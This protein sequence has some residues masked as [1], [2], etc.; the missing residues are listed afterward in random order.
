ML[1]AAVW[2]AC[3]LPEQFIW[4]GAISGIIAGG[5]ISFIIFKMA[6]MLFTSLAGTTITMTGMLA[7]FH[8]YQPTTEQVNDLVHNQ[9]W[10]LPLVLIV[11]TMVGMAV[12]NKLVRNSPNWEL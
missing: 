5:M 7:L 6:V 12:Q 4:A 1:G 8:L 11:P 3:E 2:Y 9:N 10:F